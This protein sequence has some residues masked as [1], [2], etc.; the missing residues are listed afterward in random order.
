MEQM[1]E[2][3]NL[4]LS[5]KEKY[6]KNEGVKLLDPSLGPKKYWSILNSFLG[7]KKMPVLYLIMMNSSQIIS[8]KLIF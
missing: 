4:I 7:K 3:S 8:A 1:T 2:T 5:A 6:Y